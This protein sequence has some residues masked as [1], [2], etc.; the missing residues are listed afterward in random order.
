[1]LQ[2][3]NSLRRMGLKCCLGRRHPQLQEIC[4]LEHHD[5]RIESRNSIIIDFVVSN[6]LLY[7]EIR[8][9][10]HVLGSGFA[11]YIPLF[12]SHRLSVDNALPLT[13]KYHITLHNHSPL[14]STVLNG[15]P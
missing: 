13:L 12:L 6:G 7:L 1:M 2:Q 3:Q 5:A 9:L 10:E 14:Y 11:N 15:R 4:T 8:L